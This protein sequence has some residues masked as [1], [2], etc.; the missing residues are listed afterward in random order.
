MSVILSALLSLHSWISLYESIWDHLKGIIQIPFISLCVYICLRLPLPGNGS[1][2]VPRLSGRRRLGNHFPA[3]M[4][5]R[6]DGR[7][8]GHVRV[9]IFLYILLSLLGNNS[10]KDLPR[11]RWVVGGIVLSFSWRMKGKKRLVL[12]RKCS[13]AAV[14]MWWHFF[15]LKDEEAKFGFKTL[16][17]MCSSARASSKF[18]CIVLFR[19]LRNI[20]GRSDEFVILCYFRTFAF[21]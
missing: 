9:W 8:S 1:L 11:Q 4:N 6:N 17:P 20:A 7:N 19:L 18:H 21:C 5:T 2:T 10:V 3:T 12:A 15:L 14:W 16:S 13:L